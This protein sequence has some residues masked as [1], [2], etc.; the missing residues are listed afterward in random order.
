M[1][2][3]G[4][5]AEQSPIFERFAAQ[6][7]MEKSGPSVRGVTG[8]FGEAAAG[9]FSD[10]QKPVMHGDTLS[11]LA[12]LCSGFRTP[13]E[14]TPWACHHVQSNS[15]RTAHRQ[16]E[17]DRTRP[18]YAQS[19][20]PIAPT[21]VSLQENGCIISSHADSCQYPSEEQSLGDAG[22]SGRAR[23]MRTERL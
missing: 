5:P 3:D 9:S 10:W 20:P 11:W 19:G 6:R 7:P 4:H 23:P 17:G 16:G 14:S 18:I 21:G 15:R 13:N 8:S 22:L 2:D 1:G 12:A